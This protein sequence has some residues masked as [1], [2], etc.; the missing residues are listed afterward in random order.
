MIRPIP[1]FRFAACAA[2]AALLAHS[3]AA[4]ENLEPAANLK[5]TINSRLAPDSRLAYVPPEETSSS[6]VELEPAV[7][8]PLAAA[9]QSAVEGWARFN[10]AADKTLFSAVRAYYAQDN[11]D[12]AW[13]KDGKPSAQARA[14]VEHIANA[15]Y[16]GLKA[17][18][19]KLPALYRLRDGDPQR[20]A[21]ADVAFSFQVAR[22]ITHLAAGRVA[23]GAVSSH[24]TQ[25]PQKPDVGDILTRL[26]HDDDVDMAVRFFEP[27][28]PQY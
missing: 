14:M 6:D 5:S 24:L 7:L 21:A 8:S 15:R 28:H 11:Y 19:Y 2:L 25:N 9:I 13:M 18:D 3:A 17:S 4:A 23:P 20:A 12:P 22:F 10:N 1:V 16:D 26:A 27:P